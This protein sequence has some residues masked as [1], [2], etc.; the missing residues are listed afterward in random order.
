[1]KFKPSLPIKSIV[2]SY[3]LKYYWIERPKFDGTQ[4]CYSTDVESFYPLVGNSDPRTEDMQ[5]VLKLCNSCPFK[6]QCFEWAI[7]H[8]IHGI[9][10]GTSEN[11][12]KQFRAKNKVGVVP[13][14]Y[15]HEFFK[16]KNPRFAAF[17]PA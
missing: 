3:G 7:C 13:L 11:Y 9:W 2:K 10:G 17:K 6:Q 14:E 5:Y 16:N 15:V 4:S 1:M 12:R 8:E